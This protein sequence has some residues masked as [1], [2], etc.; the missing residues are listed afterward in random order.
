[1]A[2]RGRSIAERFF[3]KFEADKETLALASQQAEELLKEI[4]INSP[5]L[6]HLVTTRCKSPS[7]LWLK[8][9]DKKYTQ[10]ARQITDVIAARIITYYKDEVAIIVKILNDALEVNQH[11]SIDKR[12]QLASIEF[13]YTSIHLIARVKGSWST[14][15]K[16]FALRNRWFEIQ[17]RSI[18]EHAWSEIEHEV[19]YKSGINYPAF[20]KRRFARI[21]GAIEILEDE[22]VA[23]RD[24]R[25][26]LIATYKLQY[27]NGQEDMAEI[28][29][30]RLIALLESVRPD[31]KGWREA[32]KRGEPFPPHIDNR[33]VKALKAVGIR[34]G[35]ALRRTLGSKELKG[36]E[37]LFVREHRILEP[38]SHLNTAR[39]AVFVHGPKIFL[40]YFPEMKSDPAILQ[41]L[42][43]RT[44][45][46]RMKR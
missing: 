21:A 26:E 3:K 45:R 14:S 32:E 39:L 6:V 25:D 40:D 46:S 15:P 44:R 22:F 27:D 20:I 5:A 19:V 31:S 29:S 34:N 33:C 35:R 4:L 16:Y 13:G 28:D 7:S 18:L 2:G 24:H 10:P 41:L 8:L 36:A 1:M 30:V 11:Q 37:A 42:T 17:V 38:I 12:E 43:H 23:L 9:R